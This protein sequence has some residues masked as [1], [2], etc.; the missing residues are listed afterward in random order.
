MSLYLAVVLIT[1][2]GYALIVLED[3]INERDR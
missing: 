1:L 3:R 2:V